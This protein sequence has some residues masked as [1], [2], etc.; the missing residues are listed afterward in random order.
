MKNEKSSSILKSHYIHQH[1]Y[2][3]TIFNKKKKQTHTHI[4]MK[5]NPNYLNGYIF[6]ISI[7][8]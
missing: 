6:I 1:I 5:Q 2:T 7:F 3:S 8:N 4:Y